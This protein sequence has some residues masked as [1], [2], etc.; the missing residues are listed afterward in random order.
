MSINTL[1]SEQLCEKCSPTS[2]GFE[3]TDDLEALQ[4]VIGQPR[5][6]N[7]L[8]LGSE[9][10]GKGFNIFVM[11][12]PD[13]GRTTLSQDYL[14]RKAASEPTPDDWC[15]V[16]NFK[17]PRKPKA[18]KL[19][20]GQSVGLKEDVEALI[21]HCQ[22]EIQKTFTSENYKKERQL[23]TEGLQISRPVF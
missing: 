4:E 15:Y 16:T 23:L 10:I 20:A 6:L 8:E 14:K 1:S 3:T 11:G 7:A 22:Q 12:L 19:P 2:L 21:K 9:V 18:L 13:S 5:A 17:D